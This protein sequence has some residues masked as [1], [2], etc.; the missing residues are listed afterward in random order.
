MKNKRFLPLA[1]CLMTFA[2]GVNA[3]RRQ[4]PEQNGGPLLKTESKDWKIA[5]DSVGIK[6]LTATSDPYSA[7]LIKGSSLGDVMV[8]YKVQDGMLQSIPSGRRKATFDGQL[9]EYKDKGIGGVITMTQRFEF[10]GTELRWS[11]CLANE[12][13]FPIDI[14]DLALAVPWSGRGETPDDIFER[15]FTKHASISGD[16]SF[17]YFT[18]FNG[19]APYFML[20]PEKGTSLEYFANTNGKYRVFVHSGKSGAR[21]TRG[22]WRQPHTI[23]HIAPKGQ[24]GDRLEVAFDY[25]TADSYAAMREQLVQH[26]G[27]DTKVVPGLTV[28]RGQKALFALRTRC[29]VDDVKAEFPEETKIEFVEKK[30]D[31]YIYSAEFKRLGENELTVTFDKSRKTYLEFFC[32]LS[33]KELTLKRSAFLVNHQ[34][35]RDTGKWY[36]GLYGVYDMVSGQLRGPDN[37]DYFDERTTYF[38]ASDDPILGKAPF[39]ASK[40][41]VWP[42]EKE[43]ESLEYHIRHFVWGGLQRTESEHPYEYGV[44]GTPNWYINRHQDLRNTLS[45]NPSSVMHTWRTY[46]Y[47]HVMMLW[48]EMY[49][50]AKNYPSMIHDASAE[51]YLER[52]FQTA[53]VY[54]KYPA[55]LQG[56][57]YETYKWGAYNELIIP[58]LIDE[59]EDR[60]RKADAD[61]L[62]C[63]WEKKVKYFVY[64]D[65][66][67][68]R[69][70]YDAD[71]TAFESTY[72]LALYGMR[73]KMQPDENLWYDENKKVWYS[74]KSVRREDFT[75]FLERQ[76]LANL[77]CRGTLENQ[78]YLLGSDYFY[79]SDWSAMS[80]MARMG[81]WGLLDYGLR[82]AADP[83]DLIR[84]GYASHLGEFGVVNAG[85]EESNYGY[86]Q[87]GKEKDGAMGQAFTPLKFGSAWIGT[88]EPRGP[89]R[90]CGEGDLGMC[91]I[92]RT[93]ATVLA[94]DPL[95][96]W[97][98]YGGNL[99]QDGKAFSFVPNDGTN[100]NFYLI[101]DK[102]RVGVAID[103]GHWSES[104]PMK[105]DKNLRHITLIIDPQKE[106]VSPIHLTINGIKGIKTPKVCV[107]GNQIRPTTDRYGQH[108][109]E[110]TS[111][112]QM[113]V[114]IDL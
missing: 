44:Y 93:A 74:H 24:E 17:L 15:S 86:W 9:I 101:T 46:D 67:P 8:S 102:K 36:D 27:I 49:K 5:Y 41:A 105:V 14:Y 99:S 66:Y 11:V 1:L 26:Q 98:L 37:P 43:I 57:Y 73:N 22:T 12:S 71:R 81:G 40:N 4:T 68:Y 61:S 92:T 78:W 51:E 7:D 114:E 52:A 90:Y 70:E 109:F 55:E 80:Y 88:Q 62:R 38:L 31:S 65:K 69:S 60:G 72:A 113:T 18:R 108:V 39:V 89:W 91:A 19:Q 63:E 56:F 100:R 23:G 20:I 25:V 21:E 2:L 94:R 77:A 35:F 87:P 33:P 64:D 103:G 106:S 32:S 30:G 112:Q 111:R 59:L 82:F 97:I 16:A 76:A 45:D 107:G 75:D 85:D 13:A 79:S 96:G 42:D 29:S 53:R 28:P 104:V 48:W 110:L 83:Y 10:V 84:L 54:F 47:P 34:Q 50:I 58:D 95:F 6:Q 3:Q